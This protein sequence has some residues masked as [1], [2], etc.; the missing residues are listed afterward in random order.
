MSISIESESIQPHANTRWPYSLHIVQRKAQH[1]VALE[2]FDRL[3]AVVEQLP[4]EVLAV[5]CMVTYR[6]PKQPPVNKEIGVATCYI[7]ATVAPT[8]DNNPQDNAPD[9]SSLQGDNLRDDQLGTRW[10][11][12]EAHLAANEAFEAVKERAKPYNQ[13]LSQ[14]TNRPPEL[15]AE[16]RTDR[17]VKL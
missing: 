4:P 16:L 1:P 17:S 12:S 2:L 15:T 9:G 11:M 7:D 10:V 14:P 13:H 3:R 5:H 8:V 6:V